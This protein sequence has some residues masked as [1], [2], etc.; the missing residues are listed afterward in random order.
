MPI[1]P[2]IGP[3]W[4]ALYVVLGVAL[5]AVPFVASM[6]GAVLRIILP[7]L[8]VALLASGATGW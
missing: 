7:I 4:R 6:E 2:N 8:G 1:K 3:T 5:I